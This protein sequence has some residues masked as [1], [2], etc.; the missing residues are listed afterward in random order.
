MNLSGPIFS[1]VDSYVRKSAGQHLISLR[2]NNESG[3]IVFDD[4]IDLSF[5]CALRVESISC[6]FKLHLN[7]ATLM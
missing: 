7:N 2:V 3:I 5:D 6:S 4:T 1:H